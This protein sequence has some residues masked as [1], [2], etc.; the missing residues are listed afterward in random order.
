MRKD[1]TSATIAATADSQL[2]RCH[3]SL[4][5]QCCYTPGGQYVASCRSADGEAGERESWTPWLATL[6]LLLC[7]RDVKDDIAL[8]EVRYVRRAKAEA[9][10][11]LQHCADAHLRSD[12]D[13]ASAAGSSMHL[14]LSFQ[15]ALDESIAIL[16][17]SARRCSNLCLC[18]W[19]AVTDADADSALCDA[20]RRSKTAVRRC[21]RCGCYSSLCAMQRN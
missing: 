20:T 17:A 9:L 12:I 11:A 8:E 14:Q 21:A 19:A 4:A 1:V 18:G 2:H 10:R 7:G 3:Q 13:V 16:P 5:E 15:R 6:S